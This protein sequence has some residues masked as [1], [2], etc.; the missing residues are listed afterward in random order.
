MHQ[1]LNLIEGRI[2][3]VAV[4]VFEM[5][6]LGSNFNLNNMQAAFSQL[7]ILVCAFD[8]EKERIMP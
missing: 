6:V 2:A 1:L 5:H 7:K 4:V 3:L 8:R